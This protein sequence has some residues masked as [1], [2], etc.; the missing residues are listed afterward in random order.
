MNYDDKFYK[1]LNDRCR[2][3]QVNVGSKIIQKYKS[4]SVIDFG[5]GSGFY[6][7]GMF[8]EG[9]K[10]KGYEYSLEFCKPYIPKDILGCI[11]A[12]DMG[13]KLV[14]DIQ[15]DMAM[16]IEV[17]E[18][19]P[20]ENSDNFI[21]NLCNSSSKILFSSSSSKDGH[22]DWGH[23]NAQNHQYW[24]DKFKKR[25]YN[26]SELDTKIVRNIFMECNIGR[27][28]IR[29]L[30]KNVMCFVK[31]NLQHECALCY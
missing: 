22:K 31:N 18:H 5:C 4:N 11:E 27:I 26:L 16:S 15:Y 21:D 23:V 19:I 14:S 9:A 29:Y 28:Y 7:Y 30:S 10:V 20:E 8:K 24:I 12:Y 1:S 2:E 13:K 3:W 6:L 25:Q 17:A